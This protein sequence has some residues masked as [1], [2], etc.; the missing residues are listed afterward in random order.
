MKRS[1]RA[2]V[3]ALLTGLYFG[4][5]GCQ[6][7]AAMMQEGYAA[8]AT[9]AAPGEALSDA[10]KAGASSPRGA[11]APAPAAQAGRKLIRTAELSIEVERY[12]EA[13]GKAAEIA[14]VNGGYVAESRVAVGDGGKRRGTLTLR[15][16]ADRFEEALSALKALGD[17]R[18]EGVAAQDITKAYTDLETRLRVKREAEARM[19]EILRT[20]TAKLSDVVEAERELTRLVEEIEQM[21][22]ERRYYDQQV[23]LSTI[24]AELYEPEAIVRR[25]AFAPIGEALRSAMEVLSSSVAA[26]IYAVFL[27]LP[28]VLL[29]FLFWKVWRRLR[30]RR[31][32][33]KEAS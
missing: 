19:R 9:A 29:A 10:N 30:A 20:K 28:W 8:N 16:R 23:A 22:G 3:A 17:V 4:A 13:A 7:K 14:R 6:K 26:L 11:P 25:G 5:W 31:T 15:V 24:S 33:K 27:G 21:E 12:E 32:A 18:S 1:R 2:L